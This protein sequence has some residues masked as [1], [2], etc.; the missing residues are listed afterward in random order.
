MEKTCRPV[1]MRPVVVRPVAVRSMCVRLVVVRPVSVQRDVEVRYMD[2]RKDDEPPLLLQQTLQILSCP[3]LHVSFSSSFSCF[4][5]SERIRG[6]LRPS[7]QGCEQMLGLVIASAVR[8][9][10]VRAISRDDH[11]LVNAAGQKH[12]A[13]SIINGAFVPTRGTETAEA[14]QRHSQGNDAVQFDA[15]RHRCGLDLA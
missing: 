8:A 15:L 5:S 14:R 10:E 7:F 1:V 2:V 3:S 9:G 12:T 11:G 4:F 13:V 6:A